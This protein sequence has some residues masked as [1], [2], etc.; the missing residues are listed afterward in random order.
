MT[1]FKN[2]IFDIYKNGVVQIVGLLYEMRRSVKIIT[3]NTLLNELLKRELNGSVGD[4]RAEKHN[5]TGRSQENI[6]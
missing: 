5:R 3:E 4:H 2:I 6:D 1:Y